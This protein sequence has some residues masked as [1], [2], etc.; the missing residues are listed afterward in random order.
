MKAIVLLLLCAISLSFANG[1]ACPACCSG[2][3]PMSFGVVFGFLFFI[4][5]CFVFALI[6]WAVYIWFVKGKEKKIS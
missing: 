6:F 1:R 5:A 2:Q 3:M 4:I